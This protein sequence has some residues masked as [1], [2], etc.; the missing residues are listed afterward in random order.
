[1][2]KPKPERRYDRYGGMRLMAEAGGYV[3]MRRDGCMPGL[4][5]RNEWDALSRVPLDEEAKNGK[6]HA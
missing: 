6:R 1:M 3:M 5:T 2:P 4:M